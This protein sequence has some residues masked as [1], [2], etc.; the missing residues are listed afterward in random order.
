MEEKKLIKDINILNATCKGGDEKKTF[1]RVLKSKEHYKYQVSLY[2]T[3]K[4]NKN[5]DRQGRDSFFI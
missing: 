1:V 3:D 5:P 4:I 2:C